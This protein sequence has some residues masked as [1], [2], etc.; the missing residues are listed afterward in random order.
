MKFSLGI[1][2]GVTI[3]LSILSITGSVLNFQEEAAI[4]HQRAS[5]NCSVPPPSPLGPAL[6][7]YLKPSVLKEYKK[8]A[9]LRGD[10]PEHDYATTCPLQTIPGHMDECATEEQINAAYKAEWLRWSGEQP[11]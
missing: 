1:I 4:N 6:V 8:L 2:I 11:K 10:P 5:V 3:I 7:C 9:E